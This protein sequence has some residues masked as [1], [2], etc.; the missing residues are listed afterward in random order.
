M[1]FGLSVGAFAGAVLFAS[2]AWAMPGGAGAAL[3]GQGVPGA[4]IAGQGADITQ[5]AQGCGR[6]G[7]RT[8]S[9]RCAYGRPGYGPP[10][11]YGRPGY[12]RPVYGRP[13]YGP[14]R[15]APGPRCF[16]QHTPYGPRRVCR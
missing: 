2:A 4:G 7:W 1:K 12:G 11:G 10:P 9:G 3:S 6:G 8:P 16:V 5:V 15:Y 13:A 14:P